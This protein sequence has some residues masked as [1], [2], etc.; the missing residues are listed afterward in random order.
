MPRFIPHRS[1]VQRNGDKRSWF[2]VTFNNYR[3]EYT[4]GGRTGYSK[5]YAYM[6]AARCLRH[7][8]YIKFNCWIYQ[9]VWI[10]RLTICFI[11]L[12][13]IIL[14]INLFH[15]IS[16]HQFH[17]P[18]ININ[19]SDVTIANTPSRHIVYDDDYNLEYIIESPEGTSGAPPSGVDDIDGDDIGLD[20]GDIIEI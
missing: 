7:F 9:W 1:R 13:M 8:M 15:H 18:I 3:I 11:F 4:Y 17:Q 5:E 16:H 14:M 2:T 19:N 20:F 12:V 10:S 6:K